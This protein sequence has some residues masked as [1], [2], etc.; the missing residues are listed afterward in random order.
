MWKNEITAAGE[1]VLLFRQIGA[2]V[3][4]TTICIHT[5]SSYI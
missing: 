1:C 4:D 3:V 2:A 5:F